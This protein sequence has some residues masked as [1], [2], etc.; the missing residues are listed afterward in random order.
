MGLDQYHSML[1]HHGCHNGVARAK[2][3]PLVSFEDIKSPPFAGLVGKG[4]AGAMGWWCV[5]CK[6]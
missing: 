6:M 2:A 5:D 3:L 1:R 4:M